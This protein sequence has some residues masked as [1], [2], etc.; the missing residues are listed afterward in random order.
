MND[1]GYSR[2][3]VF[4]DRETVDTRTLAELKSATAHGLAE[5]KGLIERGAAV[6]DVEMFTNDWYDGGAAAVLA[7]LA[8]W[9]ARSVGFTLR[10]ACLGV[11]DEVT[12]DQVVSTIELDALRNIVSAGEDERARMEELDEFRF[13]GR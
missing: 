6:L 11:G 10:E 2:L 4:V 3:L 12:G 7:L 1:R 9:E 5:L 13:G 8:K